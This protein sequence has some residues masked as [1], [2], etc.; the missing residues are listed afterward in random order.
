MARILVNG[1]SAKSGG[2]KSILRNLLGA[3]ADRDTGHELIVV[4]PSTDGYREFSSPTLRLVVL[5]DLASA[6]GLMSFSLFGVH[7]ILRDERIDVLFNP[8]DI[9]VR[10][11]T[12]QI[13][14]FDWPYAAFPDSPAWSL[15]TSRDLLVRR[16]KLALFKLG[17]GA[18]DL[19]LVQSEVMANQIRKHYRVGKI[20]IM[21]NAVSLENLAPRKSSTAQFELPAGFLFL[22]L[23]AYYTHKNLEVLLP[24]AEQIE[25]QGLGLRIVTTIGGKHPRAKALLDEIEKRGLGNVWTDLGPVAMADVPELYQRCDALLLPTLLESFSGTYVEAMF[26]RK[27][28][29]TSNLPFATGVCRDAARYFEP[30]NPDSILQEMRKI[31]DDVPLRSSLV[32]KGE[33]LLAAMP[34][35]SDVAENFLQWIDAVQS[36]PPKHLVENREAGG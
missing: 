15:S 30:L 14:L 3:L 35:W 21:P 11:R 34:D 9:P 13:F 5:K 29:L 24:V 4:V 7:R 1:M 18:I 36:I 27:P 16:T 2:G 17:L 8:S 12:K 31:A 6:A 23:S 32:E 19:M 33:Q 22:C 28:I 20:A 26:H 10:T 25:R